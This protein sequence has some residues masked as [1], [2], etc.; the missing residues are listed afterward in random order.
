MVATD[1]DGVPNTA[2]ASVNVTVAALN[3]PG[4]KVG[5]LRAGSAFLQDINGN[6]AV[7]GPDRFLAAFAPPGGLLPGDLAVV[8]DWNG[9]GHAKAGFYRPS[10]GKWWLDADN[11][12]TFDADDFSYSFGGLAGDLPFVGDWN[13]VAGVSVN[14]TCIG[15]YRS[16]GSVWLLDLNCNGT[17]DNTPADLSSPLAA[18]PATSQW[19][20]TGPARRPGL[21]GEEIR[22]CGSSAGRALLLG[23]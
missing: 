3:M 23:A 15:I 12:G 13:A 21:G 11:N 20:A 19:S 18:F 1:S 6:A 4:T 2:T 14:K 22:T 17:F 5:I 16:N 10:G 9:D 7:D 8:G